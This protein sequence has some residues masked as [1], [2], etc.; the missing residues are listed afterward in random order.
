MYTN[1]L[2]H[3]MNSEQKDSSINQHITNAAPDLPD[4]RDWYYQPALINF[5][6]RIDAPRDLYILNQKEEPACTGFALAAVIN[7]LNQQRGEDNKKVSMRMLYEMAKR[8]DE[9]EGEVYSGSSCRGAIKGWYNMGVAEEHLWSYEPNKPGKFSVEAA[10]NARANTVGAYYRL[11]H[12]IVDFHAA[13][14]EAGVIYCSARVHKGWHKDLVSNGIIQSNKTQAGSHAFA[15]VGYN[16]QGFWVQN[17]WGTQWGKDGLAIWPYEDWQ[18]NIQDAWVLRLALATPQIWH[19][20]PKNHASYAEKIMSQDKPNRAELAG[21]FAHIDDGKFKDTGKY[22]S[23]KDDIKITTNLLAES[24]DYDHVLFYA[25]GGLNSPDTSAKRIKS[26]K[27]VFK[28]NR[29]YPFHF[30]YDTGLKEELKDLIFRKKEPVNDRAGGVADATDW[31]I[32]KLTRVPGRAFWREMKSGARL[33]FNHNQA[34]TQVLQLFL[35]AI[36]KNNQQRKPDQAMKLHL[37]GHSTGAILLGWLLNRLTKFPTELQIRINTAALLAPA[38]TVGF[39]KTHYHK[40][41]TA[42][43]KSLGIDKL[44][45]YN[46]SSKLETDDSV[47]PYRKSLLYLVS[48]AFEEDKNSAILGMQKYASQVPNHNKLKRII[49]DGPNGAEPLSWSQ[50]HGGFDNDVHTMNSL[51]INILKTT[52]NRLFTENDLDY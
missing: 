29:I 5:E 9:W 41:L 24:K 44:Y 37:V 46:L 52:P 15:I 25:H 11:K 39:Y 2:G 19:L 12:R 43:T 18:I 27:E 22:W 30:M 7:Y 28:N 26:M 33:P 49:A 40:A 47:G 51:L 6:N 45:L 3:L 20:E 35:Q 42:R 36:N 38:A 21:H 17:S 23:N 31:L 10:K 48:R 50:S 34:G 32:E 8:N 14:N 16:E 13:L 1:V 4:A